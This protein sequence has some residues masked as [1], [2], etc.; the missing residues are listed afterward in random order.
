M[1]TCEHCIHN[2]KG[3]CEYS[4]EYV[5]WNQFCDEADDGDYEGDEDE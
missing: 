2:I 1:I 5:S 4:G 3:K